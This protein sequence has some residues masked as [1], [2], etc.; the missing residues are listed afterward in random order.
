MSQ[1]C[2]G[3]REIEVARELTKKYE[4]H[5]GN[6]IDKV[7]NSFEEREEIKG[8]ITIVIKGINKKRDA[9]TD[10]N[11]LKREL[12]DLVTAGLSLSAASSY[13]AKKN[14]LKKSV[15]YNLK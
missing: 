10:L 8:E 13:L 12:N 7:V 14:R 4:E 6:T 15:V 9:E 5:I 3:Q 11:D 1:F 2:G